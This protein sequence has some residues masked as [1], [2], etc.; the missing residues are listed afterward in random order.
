M[1]A[2]YKKTMLKEIMN[3]KLHAKIMGKSIESI[4]VSKGEYDQL[5]AEI[6]CENL[7]GMYVPFR[8]L[9]IDIKLT[10]TDENF[11]LSA[12]GY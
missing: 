3:I 6:D 5:S 4:A 12:C 1:K 10:R 9:G 7:Q 11:D 2:I 8:C